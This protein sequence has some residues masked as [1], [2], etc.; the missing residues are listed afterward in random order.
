MPY[1]HPVYIHIYTVTRERVYTLS[2]ESWPRLKHAIYPVWAA[3]LK[4]AII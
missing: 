4:R 3:K 2:D 1:V